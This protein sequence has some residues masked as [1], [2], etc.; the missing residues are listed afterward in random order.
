MSDTVYPVILIIGVLLLSGLLLGA[1]MLR[2]GLPLVVG[3]V[4]AG[5]CFSPGLLGGVFD[6]QVVEWSG[7]LTTIALGIIA[8]IIGGSV[9]IP[10]L[11][12]MGRLI[13]SAAVGE[14]LGAVLLVFLAV[15]MLNPEINGVPG[16][17]LALVLGALAASTA[18]AA[19]VAVLHQYRAKGPLTTV[20]LGAVA[21]DDALGII[22]FSLAMVIVVDQSMTEGIG[23]ALWEIAGAILWGGAMGFVLAWVGRQV[24]TDG[25][26]LSLII[27]AILV[28]VGLAQLW[29]LAYL[30]AAITLGFSA[31]Y[32]LRTG[33]D[34][35]L[36]P[37]EFIEELVFL[38]FFTLAGAHFQ[39]SVFYE[40]LDLI[41]IYFFARLLGKML[42]AGV[43]AKVAG[44]PPQV[45]R[46]LGWGLMPQAGIAIGLALLIGQAS[47]SAELSTVIVNVILATTL[48]YELTGPL[49]LRYAL[50]KANELGEKR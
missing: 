49:A 32:F 16:W 6:I 25:L 2:I 10:Q 1:L 38:I 5:I 48:L 14:S 42:G 24:K 44:A 27:A 12:R 31:R 37:V 23:V 45:V 26:R 13:L 7:D 29:Q 34:R 9:T 46:W 21:L 43:G 41:L 40:H 18:P 22:I 35:L 28:V 47:G 4:L 19:T 11:R 17:K 36:S 50:F 8:Y 30:L 20:L 3:Y 39:I 15:F 33:G